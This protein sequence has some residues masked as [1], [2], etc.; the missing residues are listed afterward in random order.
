MAT[1]GGAEIR[2][3]IVEIAENACVLQ[4]T[5]ADVQGHAIDIAEAS[6]AEK[7]KNNHQQEKEKKDRGQ[8]ESD[9]APSLHNDLLSDCQKRY[10][11]MI[12]EH[13]A[14]RLLWGL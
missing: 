6:D 5:I 4:P 14:C 11:S 2:G 8:A 12:F 9:R 7:A 1:L 3:K 13:N 10:L